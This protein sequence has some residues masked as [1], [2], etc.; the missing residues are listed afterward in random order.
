MDRNKKR[1]NRIRFLSAALCVLLF[2]ALTLQTALPAAAVFVA[3][4]S[5]TTELSSVCQGTDGKRYKITAKWGAEAG[6]PADAALSVKPIA[7]T[8][9]TFARCADKAEAQLGCEL[10]RDADIVLFDISIVSGAD[11]TV[12]Y[13]PAEGSAVEMS[14]RLTEQPD[15]E[16]GVLHFGEETERVE[17]EVDGRTL[18]FEAESFS[19]YGFVSLE[20]TDAI[21]RDPAALGREPLYIYVTSTA[22][23]I[24]YFCGS[25]VTKNGNTYIKKTA[26]NSTD[27]AVR[28]GFEQI[29]DSLNQYYMYLPGE[30]GEKKYF[31]FVLNTKTYL[32]TDPVNA[33]PLKAELCTETMS[34]GVPGTMFL[35]FMDGNTKYYLN[36]RQ[37]EGGPGFNGS[38]YTDTGSRLVLTNSLEREGDSLNLDGKTYAIAWLAANNHAYA[39]TAEAVSGGKLKAAD[40]YVRANPLDDD[41]DMMIYEGAD[42]DLFTFHYISES[43]YYITVEVGGGTK[44]LRIEKGSVTLVDTPD[45]YSVMKVTEGVGP[46]AEQIRIVGKQAGQA[47]TLPGGNVGN[48]YS[49]VNSYNQYNHLMLAEKSFLN[50]DDFVPYTAVKVDISDNSQVHNG[51]Q[52]IVYTRIWNEHSK[53]YEFYAIDHDGSLKRVFDEGDTLRWAG[54]QINTL[55]WDFT[56]YYYWFT[57]IPNHYYELQNVYSGK[58]IAP[59]YHT[60]QILSDKT[61]GINLNGRRYG[62]YYSTILAWDDY[63]YDYAGLKA[64]DDSVEAV[65]KAQAQDF[66]FAVM[67]EPLPEEFSTVDTVDNNEHGITM[68]LVNFQGTKYDGG[69]RDQSQTNVMGAGSEAFL[70]QGKTPMEGLVTTDLDEYGYP[71]ATMTGKS[72]YE[73]FGPAFE[74][75]HL[76][77]ESVYEES[78]Y[79]EYNCTQNFA[80][81]LNNGDFRVYNQLGTVETSTHSQGHGWFM[82]FNDIDPNVISTYTNITDV[83]N[84]P[85]ATN[86]PRLGETLYAIPKSAAQYHFGMEME[87]SFIQS[88]SG[89]DAWGHDIIFEFAGDDDMWLYVDGEL[90]LDLGGVHSALVGKI[91]FRT[92]MVEIPDPTS[93]V[94][95]TTTLRALFEKNFRARNPQATEAEVA[96][97]LDRFFENGGTV[98]KDYSSHTMKMFYMERGAGASNLHMRFNLTTAVNGQLL[99]TK[100]VSGTDKQDYASAKF[101]YQI[102]YY[103]RDY[104]D[105]R[106]VTRTEATDEGK[107]YYDYGPHVSFV[108]YKGTS[109]PVEYAETYEGYEHVFFLKPG[110]T[111]E[112]Q[113]PSDD[114]EYYITECRLDTAIYDRVTVNGE[115]N[116]GVPVSGSIRDYATVPE[117][118]GQRK[119]VIYDNHV[120]P[121]ALRTLQITKNLFDVNGKRLSYADDPIGFRF[122]VYIGDDLDY[123]RMD[124]YYVKD[125]AGNY[126]RYDADAQA[127]VSLGKITFDALT[128]EDLSV[129]TFTTSPSGAVDKIPADYTVEIRNLLIDTKFRIEEQES[130]IPRGYD[131]IGYKR[132]DGSYIVEEGDTENSGTIRDNANPHIIVENHRGWGLTVEKIWT[133][134]AFMTSH[135]NIYF[136]VYCKGVLLPETVREMKTAFTDPSVPPETSVYYYFPELQ[137]KTVFSDYTVAEVTVGDGSKDANGN[138]LNVTPISEG[139]VLQNGGLALGAAAPGSFDYYV[140]YDVGEPTG[141]GRNVRTDTV[142]NTRPGIRVLKT[143]MRGGPLSGAV[144]TLKYPDGTD[145]SNAS[146]TSDKTGLVTFLYPET[147]KTYLLTETETPAGYA[148]LTDTLTLWLEDGALR[149]SGAEN[150][151]VTVSEADSVGTVTVS[152]KNTR[153]SFSAVKIDAATKQPMADVHFALYRQL[154]GNNNVLRRDYYPITGYADLVTDANGVIPLINE[155]LTPGTY[156]LSE[157]KAPAKYVPLDEDICFTVDKAKNVTIDSAPGEVKFTAVQND[158]G[159]LIQTITVPN[160]KSIKSITLTPQTL[161]ADFGLDIRY[162]VK[163]NNHLVPNGSLYEYV[164]IAPM[165]AYDEYGTEE[166]PE[167]LCGV[168]EALAGSFG[169]LTLSAEGEARY[170]I[171]TMSFTGEDGFCLVA[172]VTRIGEKT[173]ADVYAYEKLTYIPASTVYYE[174]D[175][176]SEGAYVDGVEGTATGHNFG[177]WSVVTS[178]EAGTEQA[179]DLAGTE[180]ANVFGFDPGYTDYA[181]YSNNGAHRVSVGAVNATGKTGGQWPY[182]EFDFAGTGFDLVSVT[183]G[184][185]G[186][187]T[188]RVYETTVDENGNV[189]QGKQV[190]SQVVDTY[191][192]YKYGRFYLTDTGEPTLTATGNFLYDA[193][194]AMVEAARTSGSNSLLLASGKYMTTDVTYFAPDG[195]LSETPYYRGADGKA[196]ADVWYV[197][198][199]DSSDVRQGVSGDPNYEPNYAYAY[200]EGWL[201]NAD[202]ERALYQIPVLKIRNL[203]YGT[204]RAHVEPRFASR[205]GHY[206]TVDGYDYY[207]LYVDALRVYDP[208]GSVDDGTLVST[209]IREAY[210]GSNESNERFTTLKKVV[211]SAETL[212][213]YS[214]GTKDDPQEGLV[215]VDGSVVLNTERLNDYLAYG[216]NNELYLSKDMSVAFELCTNE[217]PTDI[218]VQMKRISDKTPKLRVTY[219]NGK[220]T[221]FTK[222]IE[223]RS[224]TDLSYS[225]MRMLGGDA[226]TWTKLKNDANTQSSGM[227]LLTNV[228]EEESLISVTNLKWTF[229]STKGE[230]KASTGGSTVVLSS[231]AASGVKKMLA[232]NRKD[233]TVETEDNAGSYEN[234]TVTLTVKTASDVETLIVKDENG[235]V[236]DGSLLD[237]AF[238]DLDDG[239]RLWT[240]SF[241]EPDDGVYTFHVSGADADYASETEAD[242]TVTVENPLP[243]EPD[244]PDGTD[245]GNSGGFASFIARIRSIWQRFLDLLR[246]ILALLGIKIG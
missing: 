172:H 45:V 222:E 195:S 89:L 87:A 204:Y 123:Y 24:F 5:A 201:Q 38:T 70:N 82:P 22:G 101:P 235:N 132:E 224:A 31:R 33:T 34:D 46:Y 67:D 50:D 218:Q 240:V 68:R 163:D 200:S 23:N 100:T 181:V 238:T 156:Y 231:A 54:T 11:K 48:G 149:V 233:M 60:G 188:V 37:S 211:V 77:L 27:G 35:Y 134:D 174:D 212:G 133:D 186:V 130:D 18:H 159:E 213:S 122:R 61:I 197:N 169:T 74:A 47:L 190:K 166:C 17:S 99:L 9:D 83:H 39:L 59:Q 244:S 223:V 88:E 243:E 165:D 92:G 208:A 53:E 153:T 234:G 41:Q 180:D 79:F 96:A 117:I 1:P 173:D 221:V 58:Y 202:A 210:A 206:E 93:G 164:G 226:I 104:A 36:M 167:L 193:T 182:M 121:N 216:P 209:V 158:A 178:G 52:V 242:I 160:R 98:F 128:E 7:K 144:F 177:K 220:N 150:D 131:L 241:E 26:P 85:L 120:S 72:L 12:T 116:G 28:F 57:R 94:Q 2:A 97:H 196:T 91:N 13:Q 148:A 62:D 14:V 78:G 109:V 112:I 19:V 30:N 136:A 229:R 151:A 71:T 80:T 127:F 119:V 230:V 179:A 21:L 65:P 215:V 203:A 139:G 4:A 129:C 110:E 246:R 43:E 205:Y 147:D 237:T 227:L 118:I 81:L 214:D 6:F 86:D 115:V 143:D 225:L 217:I 157:L 219:V 8:D 239:A 25:I 126:C 138:Y 10:D 66:Y 140:S 170:S 106:L 145:V 192:G 194:E 95:T 207:D 63:R 64:G 108:N 154:L 176:V 236:I 137:P 146:F 42:L 175:F 51:S 152:I 245:E 135:D 191:Y 162:N 73:L 183:G 232:F 56:E 49:A 189:T 199:N 16:L 84:N 107:T 142:T 55:L 15:R 29:P 20:S 187:F 111:A 161:V 75:N 32:E 168:N 184:D 44:Y 102:R 40:T 3:A 125:P 124:S 105:Y 103:D 90:V 228:G 76:F 155:T 198:R 141:A 114:T 69:A 113:F 185:T 171:G